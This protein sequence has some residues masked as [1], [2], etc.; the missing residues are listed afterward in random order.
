MSTRRSYIHIALWGFTLCGAAL[1]TFLLF[2]EGVGAVVKAV[3]AASW[4]VLAVLLY[5]FVPL[6]GDTASWRA[7]LPANDRPSPFAMFRM[8][9]IGESVTTLLPASAVGGLRVTLA[10]ASVLADVTL[11]ILVQTIFTLLGIG[12]LVGE[13]GR[14]GMIR[15]VIAGAAL[16]VLVVAMF[17]IVQH[18]GLF[19]LLGRLVKRLADDPAWHQL[20]DK[21][22]GVDSEVRSIYAASR[23]VAACSLF[24]FLS[25]AA[26]AGE[27]WIALLALGVHAGFDKALILESICQG[28]RAAVFFIPG[29]LGVQE[30]GY[31]VVGGMI[32][33]PGDTALA[34]ALIRRARELAFG[35]PGLLAWQLSEGR[36]LWKNRAP[37]PAGS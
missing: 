10:A 31:I 5:H 19:R 14:T 13:T 17:Y 26:S 4:G 15:P 37:S 25:L 3:A 30:G 32:G 28:V 8:R 16:A 35:V 34:L 23:R 18:I 9:W 1:L 21:G 29:A 11:G 22:D 2:R 24:T 6:C 33:I 20:A 7:L 12:L 36:R 27:T